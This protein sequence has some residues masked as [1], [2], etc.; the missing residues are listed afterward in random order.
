[1]KNVRIINCVILLIVAVFVQNVFAQK[2]SAKNDTDYFKSWVGEWYQEIDG[3]I[4]K[5]PRFVVKRALYDESFEESW[6]M[7]GYLAK[8]WRAWDSRTKKWDFAWMSDNGLFQIWEGKKV[9]DVWY[10]YKTF[11]IEDEEVLSR[12]AFIFPNDM[13]LIRT[14]EH[15]KDEG[16]TWK[17]RFKEKYVKKL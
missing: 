3:K 12:Q 7:E 14:S 15:S 5:E 17:L 4:A 1:M 13:T 2:H 16:K 6:V 10:M 9:G 11:I 8:A